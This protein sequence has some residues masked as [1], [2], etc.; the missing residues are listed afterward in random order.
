MQIER[1]YSKQEILETYLNMVHLG[2]GAN[3]VEA[4]AQVYFGKSARDLDLAE[5]ALLAGI[6]RWPTRYS[7]HNNPDI[8]KDRRNFVLK[9]ML[10]LEFIT[11]EQFEAARN[12]PIVVAERKPRN[13]N[14]P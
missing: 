5:S 14:A 2:H 10:E 7:P 6:I 8:A 9:R 4:G 1:K 3:G 13:V 12:Q 11:E